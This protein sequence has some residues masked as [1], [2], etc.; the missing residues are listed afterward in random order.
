MREG[1]WGSGETRGVERRA[2]LAGDRTWGSGGVVDE[3]GPLR[4]VEWVAGL[5]GQAGGWG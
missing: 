1:G 5:A 4:R 3:G 2:G